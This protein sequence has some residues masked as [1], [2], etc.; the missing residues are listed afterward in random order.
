MTRFYAWLALLIPHF[1]LTVIVITTII[2]R[3][4]FQGEYWKFL[5]I[6]WG[7]APIFIIILSEKNPKGIHFENQIVKDQPSISKFEKWT[8]AFDDPR[9]I[10]KAFNLPNL[11]DCLSI[12]IKRQR[13]ISVLATLPCIIIAIGYIIII[14]LFT[15]ALLFAH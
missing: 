4:A 12:I 1:I 7:V 10:P 3:T 11:S 6:V 15:S 9:Q 14:V 5:L 13:R 2:S 8:I